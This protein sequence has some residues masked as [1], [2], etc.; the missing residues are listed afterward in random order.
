M[1]KLYQRQNKEQKIERIKLL[2]EG[3]AYHDEHF[4]SQAPDF[5]RVFPCIVGKDSASEE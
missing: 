2:H 4:E 1:Q 5:V 3:L